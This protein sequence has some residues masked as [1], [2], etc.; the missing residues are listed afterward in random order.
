M[1]QTKEEAEA[2]K[3][4]TQSSP[5]ASPTSV[6]TPRP[7]S[8][9]STA[10]SFGGTGSGER[11]KL[12]LKPLSSEQKARSQEGLAA[13]KAT[14]AA[15]QQVAQAN[16]TKASSV[17]QAAGGASLKSWGSRAQTHL[18]ELGWQW[19]DVEQYI[20]ANAAQIEYGGA[21]E[22]GRDT[23]AIPIAGKGAKQSIRFSVEGNEWRIF[24]VGP[25]G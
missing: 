18:A 13:S 21:G 3:K 6:V 23:F 4:K 7:S 2:F 17:A 25:G 15:R 10:H 14:D 9:P 5:S 22:G 1:A 8:S 12:K 19:S 16:A 24:H 20:K 11:P